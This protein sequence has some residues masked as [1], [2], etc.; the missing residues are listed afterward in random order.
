MSLRLCSHIFV[1]RTIRSRSRSTLFVSC[2]SYVLYVRVSLSLLFCLALRM[3]ITRSHRFSARRL[4]T[5]KNETQ[6]RFSMYDTTCIHQM[7]GRNMCA[8]SCY[9]CFSR[10]FL[11][12]CFFLIQVFHVVRNQYFVSAQHE[13]KKK[14]QPATQNFTSNH[15]IESQRMTV[16]LMY[17][18]KNNDSATNKFIRAFFFDKLNGNVLCS[19]QIVENEHRNETKPDKTVVVELH[20]IECVTHE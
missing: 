17:D 20:L 14:H 15:P 2:M 6:Q 19:V 16:I 3:H 8:P 13:T 18:K 5:S 11:L 1:A 4:R 7:N 10:A 9:L 12:R